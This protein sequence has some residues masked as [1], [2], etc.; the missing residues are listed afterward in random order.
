M[1]NMRHQKRKQRATLL[2]L[3]YPRTEVFALVKCVE[4]ARLAFAACVWD[5]VTPPL[6]LGVGPL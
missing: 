2:E 3:A 5:L 6:Q 4:C 1:T